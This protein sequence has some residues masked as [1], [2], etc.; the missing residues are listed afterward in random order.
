MREIMSNCSAPVGDINRPTR[1][2]AI[3]SVEA[4][5]KMQLISTSNITVLINDFCRE[6]GPLIF[7]SKHGLYACSIHLQ[8]LDIIVDSINIAFLCA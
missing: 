2:L 7:C 8:Y 6:Y 3:V 1:F 4:T 5:S